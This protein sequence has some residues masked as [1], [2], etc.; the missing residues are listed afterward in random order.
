MNHNCD[1]CDKVQCYPQGE[2]PLKDQC[3]WHGVSHQSDTCAD[4][5][6][7]DGAHLK[8]MK[9]SDCHVAEKASQ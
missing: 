8:Q 5:D 3:L 4:I 6:Q 7:F 2:C 1:K 9:E